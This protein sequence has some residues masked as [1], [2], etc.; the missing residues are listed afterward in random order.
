MTATRSRRWLLGG[1]L[2]LLAL[3]PTLVMTARAW[4]VAIEPPPSPWQRARLRVVARIKAGDASVLI[5]VTH[6]EMPASPDILN[7]GKRST[8]AL[9]RC[10]SD[11]VNTDIR[12]RCAAM[13][14]ALGDPRAL[15]TLR[16]ALEDWD[17]FVRRKVIRALRHLPDPGSFEP[18]ARL[19]RRQDEELANRQAILATLGALS[20][21]KAV[22]LLRK[23]LGRKPEKDKPDLRPQ[24]FEA[25]WH[26]R[27]L[28]ARPTLVADVGRA[29][30]SDNSELAHLA[31][32]SA[33]ELRD[34]GLVRHLI[35][36]MEHPNEDV[37]NKAVYALGRIGDRK[38]ARALLQHLPRA[39]E[40]RMLNNIAFAL[41]RLDRA[42]F[43]T[44]I[45]KTIE[46][47]QAVIR[48]N[49]AFVVGDVRRPEG[50]P[51][52]ERALRDDSDYVK[53]S[54]IVAV[55]KLGQP[56]GVKLLE[57]FARH[58]NLSIKQEAIYALNS[59]TG[60]KRTDLIYEELLTSKKTEH[61]PEIRR[62]AAIE[63]GKLGHEEVKEFLLV[64][65]ETRR[66]G[67]SDVEQFFASRN[68]DRLRGRL[69]LAWARGRPSLTEL[70][71]RLR[72]PGALDVAGSALG[73]TRVEGWGAMAA[74]DLIG[75]LGGTRFSGLLRQE[76]FHRSPWTRAH[77]LVALTR[78][79]DEK[80][81]RQLLQELDQFPAAW[82]PR[83]VEVVARVEESAPRKL[84]L[85]ELQ[86]RAGGE[87]V[88][89]ALA[90]AAVRLQWEPEQGFFRFLE[91]LASDSAHERDQA[92]RYLQR[93]RSDKLTWLLRRALARERR[94]FTRDRLR[95][96]LDA[97]QSS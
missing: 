40:A 1:A 7:F 56:R 80:A 53:T 50:L 73:A 93:N 67:L 18:L 15:P 60:G 62:R 25:L 9:E 20:S 54:A 94:P 29:L 19:Y 84:L 70:V 89:L 51:L 16:V 90:A 11:N 83:M 46:H 41:E 30:R 13:L 36:L 37:R 65:F 2:V 12:A 52:L 64:C 92:E 87:Q 58:D 55:G 48:L 76:R 34:P 95:K 38:A 63:L 5:N 81:A 69:L 85:A 57:P 77:A 6:R 39:R 23:E 26:S 43:F 24:A 21:P 59:L 71:A 91:A 33:A 45:G 47:K 68:G 79:G 49:A 32:E 72:P 10:L 82:L 44:A 66:C 31:T 4:T 22:Q 96:L 74:I 97:R 35:P 14:G 86:K 17:V 27:H 28:Y 75:D 61:R 8:R 3:A 88:D 78:I 42:A